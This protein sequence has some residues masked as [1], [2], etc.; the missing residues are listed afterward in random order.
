[1]KLNKQG[2]TTL[3]ILAMGI[4]VLIL[5]SIFNNNHTVDTSEVLI[6]QPWEKDIRIINSD[7]MKHYLY[8]ITG[9]YKELPWAVRTSYTIIQFSSLALLVLL[10]TLFWDVHNRKKRQKTYTE[11]KNTYFEKLQSIIIST[12]EKHIQE[13]K[14]ELSIDDNTEFTYSQKL[15]LIDLFLELRT[16]I[17]INEYSIKNIQNALIA[18]SLQ[19]F[20]EE[21]LL[22]GKES[23]KQKII[24]AIRLLHM[25][26]TDSYV[27]RIINHRDRNLQKAARLYYI[28]S[29]EEDPFKYME[30]KKT[31]EVFLPW[32]MLET[33]Q[34]FEDCKN[35]NKK[36][37]SFIPAMTQMNNNTIIEFFI[38]ETAYW[39]SEKEMN[40]LFG[41]LES[42]EESLRK[43][44]LES[45]NLRKIKHAEQKLKE[46]YYEQPE[47]IKRVILYTLLVISPTTSIDFFK[48]AFENT[49][50]QLTKRM[51][52]QCL[53]KSD[54]NGR[55]TFAQMK[56]NSRINDKIL[57]LH[58]E[59]KIIEREKLSLHSIN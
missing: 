49:A 20:M 29:N 2:T 48:E 6:P 53:W 28:L 58:V 38:K 27:A 21:R 56:E 25:E 1:M 22:S 40:Y 47:N 23:E 4:I 33:H 18:F 7:Y 12:Q 14:S 55:N 19:Q 44:A 3:L 41:Y 51:A 24:Q 35:L 5:L 15:A 50:S 10:Y 26:V 57:F 37:P 11:L 54:D 59:N 43:A 16:L 34:I 8:S 36:L 9:F 52:L 39:G 45:M 42:P 31:A 30:G 17:T 32:D 13:I 46:I